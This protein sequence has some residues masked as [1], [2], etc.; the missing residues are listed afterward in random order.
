M[1]PHQSSVPAVQSGKKEKVPL[2]HAG[3]L[4]AVR[5]TWAR[6]CRLVEDRRA[7]RCSV[8]NVNVLTRAHSSLRRAGGRYFGSPDFNKQKNQSR[9]AR[10]WKRIR[11]SEARGER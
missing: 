1:S 3:F 2:M 11:V 4:S 6:I 10:G 5:L 7:S 9:S 8:W